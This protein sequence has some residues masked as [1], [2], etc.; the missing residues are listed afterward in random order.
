MRNSVPR[1]PCGLAA[2]TLL[3]AT[4]FT[5]AATILVDFGTATTQTTFD[6]VSSTDDPVNYW[7]N[8]TQ[9]NGT[10]AGTPIANLVDTANNPT[11]IALVIVSPFNSNNTAGTTSTSAPYPV[12]ATSDSLYGNTETFGGKTNV[13]PVFKL[14]GLNSQRL[15]SFTF[16]ASRLGTGGSRETQYTVAGA[17]TDSAALEVTDNI[18]NT[19]TVSNI[20]PN[21]SNEIQISLAPTANNNNANHFIYLGVLRVVD[22]PEPGAMLLLAGFAPLLLRR[23]R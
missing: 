23:R 3:M 12:D 14:T 20:S 16:Y 6:T 1:L 19:V 4:S 2:L 18:T 7:N 9:T 22:T 11:N 17:T 15:Y 8:I 21:A 13:T 5:S 10:S